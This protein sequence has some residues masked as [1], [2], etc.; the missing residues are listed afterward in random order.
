MKGKKKGVRMG[1]RGE[2]REGGGR[3]EVDEKEGGKGG[4]EG[5]EREKKARTIVSQRKEEKKEKR[6]LMT[7]SS[8]TSL[9]PFAPE[10]FFMPLYWYENCP[11][12]VESRLLFPHF[13]R[14]LLGREGTGSVANHFFFFFTFY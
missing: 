9:V 7:S 2:G 11:E 1:E 14:F 12:G 3:G 10:W 6:F 8:R 4:K 13:F 5:V